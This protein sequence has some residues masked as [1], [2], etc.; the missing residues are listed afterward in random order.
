[1]FLIDPISRYQVQGHGSRWPTCV[2][3]IPAA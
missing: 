3:G 1:M 2:R